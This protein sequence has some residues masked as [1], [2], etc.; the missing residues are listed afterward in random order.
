[1]IYLMNS[2]VLPHEMYG[3]YHYRAATLDDLRDVV[4]GKHG[5]WRSCIS[6]PQNVQLIQ[7][8]TGVCVE[9]SRAPSPMQPGDSAMV[10]RLPDRTMNPKG[11]KLSENPADWEF[12]WVHAQ[13]AAAHGRRLFGAASTSPGRPGYVVVSATSIE[14][15]RDV[16]AAELRVDRDDLHAVDL[17]RAAA[18]DGVLDLFEA[19]ATKR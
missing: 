17:G 15:A 7:R 16:A 19:S 1:V 4:R 13:D 6:Y 3:T 8:W 2:A 11:V 5:D 12:A 14:D 18:V 9:L 10:M